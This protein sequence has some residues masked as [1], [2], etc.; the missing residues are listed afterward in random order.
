MKTENENVNKGQNALGPENGSQPRRVTVVG[1]GFSGLVSAYY[2]HRAG[3]QVE[4]IEQS[5]R[6]GGLINTVDLQEGRV[7][8]AA[9]GLLNSALVEELF[10]E[11]G[12]PLIATRKEA[13]KRFILR[14]GRP[15][16]WPLGL[17]ASLSLF[18]FVLRFIFVRSRVAPRA[19]ESV[20]EWGAR[21]M[22]EEASRYTIETALQGIY[23]G[24][25]EKMSASLI[26]GRFFTRKAKDTR[27]RVTRKPRQRGTVS[28]ELGMGQLIQGLR[29]YLE[30]QGVSFAFGE[31]F[32]FE[33]NRVQAPVVVATSAIEA[34]RLLERVDPE[35]AQSL[36][37]IEIL[38]LVTTTVFFK[39]A[40]PLVQGFGCL[41][42]PREGRRVLGALMNSFI[43]TGRSHQGFSETWI[44]GGARL[45]R[46]VPRLLEMSDA[47]V[48]ATIQDERESCFGA[49]G[50]VLTY[51][52]TRWPLALPHYTVDLEHVLPLVRENRK[53][54][55]LI[56][57][58]LGEIGLAK[59][60]ERAERLPDEIRAGTR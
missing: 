26:V 23:A 37:R 35:R 50:E 8:T 22:G 24:D 41:M 10:D 36:A 18:W 15:R 13:R 28:A 40:N 39:E 30:K 52:V 16:R 3:F 1:A 53:N 44:M 43:F 47:E 19:C 31:V 51:R 48:L 14:E 38:S 58:Y 59:I 9:N 2:L 56:G 46:T 29:S 7:E 20:T 55:F 21:V 5:S 4:V 25:A 42:P 27:S 60:L 32:A 12:V 17:I 34:S 57:N 33:S 11:I 45:A 6:P 54:V 49:R